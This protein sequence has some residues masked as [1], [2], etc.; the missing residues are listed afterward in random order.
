MLVAL[1][2]SRPHHSEDVSLVNPKQPRPD[3]RGQCFRAWGTVF[4]VQGARVL[5][6]TN[7]LGFPK[8]GL[9]SGHRTTPAPLVI[10]SAEETH[11]MDSSD[12]HEKVQA[13][14]RKG[15]T[16]LDV[17]SPDY[18]IGRANGGEFSYDVL[19]WEPPRFP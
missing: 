14:R 12:H 4:F 7:S 10:N 19:V 6:I 2:F 15:I 5:N 16:D 11:P 17:F 18:L 9:A 13:H 8:V 1:G 3:L